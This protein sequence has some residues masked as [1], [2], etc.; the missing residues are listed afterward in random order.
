MILFHRRSSNVPGLSRK[1]SS[2]SIAAFMRGS[3]AWLAYT[4]H[5]RRLS[6]S[7]R[8]VV[9][10]QAQGEATELLADRIVFFYCAWTDQLVRFL[11]DQLQKAPHHRPAVGQDPVPVRRESARL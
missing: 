3:F 6:L 8:L 10:Q 9:G 2:L 7:A 1:S 11:A 4:Q 5:P